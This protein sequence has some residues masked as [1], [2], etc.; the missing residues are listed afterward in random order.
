[1]T[2]PGISFILAEVAGARVCGSLGGV[3]TQALVAEVHSEEYHP[4]RRP[5]LLVSPRRDDVTLKKMIARRGLPGIPSRWIA[6]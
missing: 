1:M 2:P 3:H 5:G 6:L 4:G